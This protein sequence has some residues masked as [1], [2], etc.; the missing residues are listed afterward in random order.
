MEEYRGFPQFMEAA[1]K[2]L[3]RRPNL[4]IIIAG[5]DKIVYGPKLK[6][7]TYK[8]MMLEKLDLD[9]KSIFSL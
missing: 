3:K 1:D 4:H 5:E 9:L 7:T 8:K 6:D 2:L